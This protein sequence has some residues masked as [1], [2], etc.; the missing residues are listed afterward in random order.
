MRSAA[1]V[2]QKMRIFI[3]L[4]TRTEQLRCLFTLLTALAS[5]LVT[6]KCPHYRI[7]LYGLKRRR[8]QPYLLAY[9]PFE[10]EV[11]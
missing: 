11:C 9:F 5:R 7:L 8:V 4:I 3:R 2:V 6:L 1:V 10:Q